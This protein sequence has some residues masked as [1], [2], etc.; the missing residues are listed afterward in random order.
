MELLVGWDGDGGMGGVEERLVVVVIIVLG[1]TK[2]AEKSILRRG[3]A[4]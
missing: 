4:A 1:H 2:N 3:E